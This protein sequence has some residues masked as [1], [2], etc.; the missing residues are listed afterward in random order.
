MTENEFK[1][2]CEL[3]F[4]AEKKLKK[5]ETVTRRLAIPPLNEFRYAGCHIARHL[6]GETDDNNI[7]DAERHCKR[8]IYDSMEIGITYYLDEIGAFKKEYDRI[9]ITDVVSEYVGD[10]QKLR[11]VQ[12]F[13]S[14]KNRHQFENSWEDLQNYFDELEKIYDRLD[15]AR[16]ELN[17]KVN[18]W[19]RNLAIGLFSVALS[20][21]GLIVAI[22]SLF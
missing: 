3:Y 12:N 6:D 4:L 1:K 10:L 14:S 2:F 13:I 7:F 17:K 16:S 5:V 9:P 8:A 21:L 11:E 15:A 18:T 20:I 19:R 22:K